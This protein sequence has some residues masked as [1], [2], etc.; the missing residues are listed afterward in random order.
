MSEASEA[1]AA[2]EMEMKRLRSQMTPEQRKELD[3]W[4]RE[5]RTQSGQ[6]LI[7]QQKSGAYDYLREESEQRNRA[8]R[9]HVLHN[10]AKA[11]VSEEQLRRDFPRAFSSWEQEQRCYELE[12]H[13]THAPAFI[14]QHG[15]VEYR[16]KVNGCRLGGV[17]QVP[18]GRY[19]Y[20][21]RMAQILPVV[22]DD[23]RAALSRDDMPEGLRQEINRDNAGSEVLIYNPRSIAEAQWFADHTPESWEPQFHGPQVSVEPY[24]YLREVTPV[25][26]GYVQCPHVEEL[27]APE[28][29]AEDLRRVRGKRSP[30]VRL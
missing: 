25:R 23:V 27:L 22:G 17:L 4:D 9:T 20:R 10:G 8:L 1:R 28:R 6:R 3:A 24:E 30:V 11:G 12:I 21:W 14:R 5:R 29:V 15:M 7:E 13:V 2:H 16:C 26:N 18:D 19:W